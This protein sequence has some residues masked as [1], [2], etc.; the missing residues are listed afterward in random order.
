LIYH[1][2]TPP[3][4]DVPIIKGTMAVAEDP[5]GDLVNPVDYLQRRE[6]PEEMIFASLEGW[7]IRKANGKQVTLCFARR[8]NKLI[9]NRDI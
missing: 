2:H 4:S 5:A 9:H 1:E 6:I 8:D 3:P 7:G